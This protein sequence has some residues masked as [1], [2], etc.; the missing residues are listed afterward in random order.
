MG[1]GWP[2][3]WNPKPVK[4]RKLNRNSSVGNSLLDEDFG[5]VF[6]G[7]DVPIEGILELQ[8]QVAYKKRDERDFSLGGDALDADGHLTFITDYLQ[9]V[10]LDPFNGTTIEKGDRIVEIDGVEVDYRIIE[11]RPGG[12]L[13][14]AGP[15]PIMFLAYFESPRDENP[16]VT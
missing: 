6:G 3:R 16:R 4:I 14:T 8:A 2:R 13:K 15:T 1:R 5:D 11:F 10:G 7:V 12:H 9:E